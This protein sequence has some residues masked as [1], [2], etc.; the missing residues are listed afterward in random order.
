MSRPSTESFR[1]R[2]DLRTQRPWSCRQSTVPRSCPPTAC[3]RE[4]GAS[5]RC[6]T[7]RRSPCSRRARTSRWATPARAARSS[8]R[9]RDPDCRPRGVPGRRRRCSSRR[10]ARDP[11]R[12]RSATTCHPQN[13]RRPNCRRSR[14]WC[15]GGPAPRR[16]YHRPPAGAAEAAAERP[17]R[18]RPPMCGSRRSCRGRASSRLPRATPNSGRPR[19]RSTPCPCRR[20]RWRRPDSSASRRSCD[21]SSSRCWSSSR[22]HCW[23]RPTCRP[24]AATPRTFRDRATRD[25]CARSMRGTRDSLCAD[26]TLRRSGRTRDC[27]RGLRRASRAFR[28]GGR[29]RA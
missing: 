24:R 15:H 28:R 1:W 19:C 16:P 7:E 17:A 25:A 2:D 3:R 22:D 4:R 20:P 29:L 12:A 21:T 5:E 10:R 26:A 9:V 13:N 6:P 8:E 14:A 18:R 27:P 11:T 23:C